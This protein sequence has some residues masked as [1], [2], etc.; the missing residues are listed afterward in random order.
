VFRILSWICLASAL[1]YF[2]RTFDPIWAFRQLLIF[3]HYPIVS[4][5]LL[6]TSTSIYVMKRQFVVGSKVRLKQHSK[7]EPVRLVCKHL[8]MEAIDSDR[9]LNVHFRVWKREVLFWLLPAS[10]LLCSQRRTCGLLLH[11]E[12]ELCVRNTTEACVFVFPLSIVFIPR[13]DGYVVT[14]TVPFTLNILE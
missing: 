2:T 7:G 8:I 12:W 9:Y 3:K 10:P 14:F 6:L 13:L 11:P 4:A 5:V 1:L